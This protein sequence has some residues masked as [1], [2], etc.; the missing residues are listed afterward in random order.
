MEYLV[1]GA[2]ISGLGACQLLTQQNNKVFLFDKDRKKLDD[3]KR[4]KL[5]PDDV[6]LCTK[7]FEKFYY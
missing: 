6:V 2:G 4:A 3:L 7:N 1:L 5:V